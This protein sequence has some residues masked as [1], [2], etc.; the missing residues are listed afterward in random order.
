MDWEDAVRAL[1]EEGRQFDLLKASDLTRA[2][3]EGLPY[4]YTSRGGSWEPSKA[5]TETVTEIFRRYA[6]GDS[7]A[8]IASRLE[9]RG[10]PTKRGGAWHPSTVRYILR[11]PLYAGRRRSKGGR[12][13]GSHPALVDGALFAKVQRR[14]EARRRRPD[15]RA[16]DTPLR[17]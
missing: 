12:W 15:Q 2:A 4:G 8:T 9:R 13:E 16:P 17:A 7:L 3:E 6:A 14:L 11:N 1:G 10:V 5:E